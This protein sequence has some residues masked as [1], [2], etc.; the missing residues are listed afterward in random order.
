MQTKLEKGA[1]NRMS[2]TEQG[3]ASGLRF[4]VTKAMGDFIKM[5]AEMREET[6]SDFL[7]WL[8]RQEVK[9]MKK[10]ES[11]RDQHVHY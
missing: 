2:K 9:R 8:V 7:R 6:I 11:R 5:R 4:R 1:W 3:P 10:K